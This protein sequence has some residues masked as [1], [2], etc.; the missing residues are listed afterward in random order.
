M[1]LMSIEANRPLHLDDSV[2]DEEL[3][4]LWEKVVEKSG[5][6]M[7]D[8]RGFK[9]LDTIKARMRYMAK[10]MDCK[11]IVLDHLHI[12]C[13]TVKGGS[14][15]S[16]IDEL[17]TDL[18]GIA[19]EC[20]IGLFIVSHVSR[21]GGTPYEEGGQ[22]SLQSL[23]GSQGIA[24]L[25]DVVWGLERDQQAEDEDA[26]N[27]TLVRC[28]KNRWTGETGVACY[29]SYNPYTGRMVECAAPVKKEDMPSEF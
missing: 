27:T 13:S 24:Q 18:R 26:R 14:E 16:H 17:M 10:A 8:H 12:V 21:S 9:D 29:L 5:V 11:Y 19:H 1:G 15:W 4:G 20:N 25:S 3:R 2:T 22:L 7:L 28:L 23:R 6:E